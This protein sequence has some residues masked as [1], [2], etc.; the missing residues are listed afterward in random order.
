MDDLQKRITRA[1][2]NTWQAIG[3]DILAAAE[4]DSVT[5]EEVIEAVMDY[6]QDYGRDKEAVT[7]FNRL[8]FEEKNDM[9]RVAFPLSRYGW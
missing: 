4:A 7:E 6:I 9:L 8:S 2:G 3:S 5:Q 1:A